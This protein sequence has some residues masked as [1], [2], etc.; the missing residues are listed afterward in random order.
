M[1]LKEIFTAKK[2]RKKRQTGA[3]NGCTRSLVYNMVGGS[4]RKRKFPWML[5]WKRNVLIGPRDTSIFQRS[6]MGVCGAGRSSTTR[7]GPNF[8]FG[9]T[10][11]R[12]AALKG[13]VFLWWCFTGRNGIFWHRRR[14]LLHRVCLRELSPSCGSSNW[15]RGSLGRPPLGRWSV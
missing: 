2:V 11:G 5:I 1:S 13:D 14:Q 12:L 6:Q 7:L 8:G 10:V 3:T 15:S 9:P 4:S